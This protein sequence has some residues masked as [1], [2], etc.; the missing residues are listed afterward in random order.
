ME[1]VLPVK[2]AVSKHEPHL[3]GEFYSY[4]QTAV[5]R[6]EPRFLGNLYSYVKTGLLENAISTKRLCKN[7]SVKCD[8]QTL[9][10]PAEPLSGTK[11]RGGSIVT[12]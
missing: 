12:L 11:C 4:K 1:F 5:S 9:K 7:T 8:I 3:L 10:I 2:T 6:Y